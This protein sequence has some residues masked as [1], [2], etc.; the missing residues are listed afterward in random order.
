MREEDHNK[1]GLNDKI[2]FEVE[3]DLDTYEN[4]YGVT[5]ILIFDYKLHVSLI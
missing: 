5:I 3:A 1:D 4:V 2:I